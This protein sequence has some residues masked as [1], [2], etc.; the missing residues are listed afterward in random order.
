MKSLQNIS[1]KYRYPYHL[2]IANKAISLL[3]DLES[4]LPYTAPSKV[5][6]LL[7][8]LSTS[9]PHP[10]P[11]SDNHTPKMENPRLALLGTKIEKRFEELKVGYLMSL[12]CN[13]ADGFAM[14]YRKAWLHLEMPKRRERL[15]GILHSAQEKVNNINYHHLLIGLILTNQSRS[16]NQPRPLSSRDKSRPPQRHHILGQIRFH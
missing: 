8:R 6:S 10:H 3:Q 16:Q 2:A 12:H 5:G 11:S 14:L 4:Y 15:R 9:G 1:S 13:S 7:R